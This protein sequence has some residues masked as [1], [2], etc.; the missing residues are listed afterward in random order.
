MYVPKERLTHWE[1][2]HIA[3]HLNRETSRFF[4]RGGDFELVNLEKATDLQYI[5]DQ[6]GG[7]WIVTQQKDG[8]VDFDRA[9]TLRL[10]YKNLLDYPSFSVTRPQAW[11]AAAG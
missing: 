3:G 6:F 7:V 11:P 5:A 8:E 10:K 4:Y 1:V 9:Q 2:T